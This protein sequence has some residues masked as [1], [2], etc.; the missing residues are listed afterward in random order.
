[1]EDDRQRSEFNM[2]VS[3]LNR[4]NYLFYA[5]NEAAI[6]L[7]AHSWFHSLMALFRELS[8]EMK[9]KEIETLNKLI[10]TLNPMLTRNSN[11]IKKTGI[12]EISESLYLKL[13]EFEI[14]LRRILKSAGLQNKMMDDASMALR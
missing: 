10:T 3:Y 4:L 2:A 8:T 1:M 9:P 6:S 7:D 14:D 13:H 11:N 5:A 12:Q